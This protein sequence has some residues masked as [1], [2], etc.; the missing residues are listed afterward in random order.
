M[1]ERTERELNSV[2]SGLSSKDSQNVRCYCTGNQRQWP[3]Y[4][5]ADNLGQTKVDH[6]LSS[7]PVKGSE[8]I[9]ST[10]TT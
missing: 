4:D 10:A 3:G 5:T 9:V 2:M 8:E 7:G 6:Y 1:L